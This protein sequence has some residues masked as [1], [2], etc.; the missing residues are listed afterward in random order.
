MNVLDCVNCLDEQNTKW[1]YGKT[2]H[3]RIRIKEYHFDASRFSESSLFK[4]PEKVEIFT[5]SG[6]KDP[7]DEFKGIVEAEGLQGILFEE[8]WSRE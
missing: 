5:T 7:E 6:L 3:S 1:V 8:V 2:T 4:I